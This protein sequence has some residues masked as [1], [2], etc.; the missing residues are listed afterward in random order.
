MTSARMS[1]HAACTR[2]RKLF[3]SEMGIS[4]ARPRCT[5]QPCRPTGFDERGRNVAS[6]HLAG[7]YFHLDTVLMNRSDG[8]LIRMVT[9]I[10]PDE[11]EHD[12]DERLQA[13]MRDALPVLSEY[14]PAQ[15]ISKA[16]LRRNA[17]G[18]T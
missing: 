18:S 5:Q 2:L 15:S 7:W 4:L 17:P 16:E 8:A 14:L 11:T 3:G 12:A 1:V 10:Q 13:F 9:Q 6:E